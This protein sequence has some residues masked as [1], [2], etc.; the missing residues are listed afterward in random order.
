MKRA[1]SIWWHIFVRRRAG[2]GSANAGR[3]L[4]FRS[5]NAIAGQRDVLGDGAEKRKI[6]GIKSPPAAASE[7]ERAEQLVSDDQRFTGIG[8]DARRSNQ[9]SH[10]VQRLLNIGDV[11]RL[12]RNR[13]GA[14]DRLAEVERQAALDH[15]PVET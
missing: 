4:L 6:V 11:H 12:A 5:P 15:R 8:V 3:C 10:W 7:G 14:A 13:D 9:V 2:E 1:G